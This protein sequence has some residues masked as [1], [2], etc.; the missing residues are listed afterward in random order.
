[1]KLN[2]E[3]SGGLETLFG[4]DRKMLLELEDGTTIK[5]LL[6]RLKL[7]MTDPRTDLFLQDG[8]V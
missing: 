3:F 7:L 5:E 4:N 1:M 8:L 2:V 6:G